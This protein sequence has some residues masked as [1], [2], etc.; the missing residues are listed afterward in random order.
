MEIFV[1]KCEEYLKSVG[2]EKEL[3]L[4]KIIVTKIKI[5]Q[6]DSDITHIF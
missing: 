2:L 4:D 1:E 6:I 5:N 3:G